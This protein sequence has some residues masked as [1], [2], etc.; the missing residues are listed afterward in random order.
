MVNS[1]TY[2]RSLTQHPSLSC[3]AIRVTNYDFDQVV[4]STHGLL[5][6]VGFKLGDRPCVYALEGSIAYAGSTVQWLRDNLAVSEVY[7]LMS[8]LALLLFSFVI[9]RRSKW[10]YEWLMCG[11]HNA[12]VLYIRLATLVCNIYCTTLRHKHSSLRMFRYL[13]TPEEVVIPTIGV[14]SAGVCTK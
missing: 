9:Q 11:M 6:T 8:V 4:P 5:S 10:G 1:K 12:Y 3:W 13:Y 2:N 7:E 14:D